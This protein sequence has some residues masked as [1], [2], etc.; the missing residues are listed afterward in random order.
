MSFFPTKKHLRVFVDFVTSKFLN[1][2]D[3]FKTIISAIAMASP[4]FHEWLVLLHPNHL[5]D[6]Q[7]KIHGLKCF[8]KNMEKKYGANLR[9]GMINR[10]IYSI[11]VGLIILLSCQTV[12]D[13]VDPSIAR[14]RSWVVGSLK[15]GA[16]LS[17]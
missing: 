2:L 8:R 14:P 4:A 15:N 13:F 6:R 3:P 11:H 12:Q 1:F 10:N 17:S 7:K 9:F 5:K 16:E